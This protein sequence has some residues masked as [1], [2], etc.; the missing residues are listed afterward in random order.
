MGGKI[1]A[2]SCVRDGGI[3][4]GKWIAHYGG[5]LGARNL[6][7]FLDGKDQPLPQAPGV[8]LTVLEHQK[9]DRVAG[10][11]AR[12]ARLSDKAAELFAAGYAM[13]IATD[14]D[15]YLVADPATGL[16]LA[17]YLLSLPARPSWSAL[18]LDV[19]QHLEHETAFDPARPF[20]DQ[21]RFAQVSARYTKASVTTRPL[22]WG[23][24]MHRVKGR[25]FRIAPDLFLIH[26]GMIDAGIAGVIGRDATRAEAGWG[27]HQ[28]RREALFETVRSS[29]P[30]MA[31][32]VFAKARRRMSLLRPVYAWNKPGRLPGDA[33]VVLPER[34][35]GLL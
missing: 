5:A 3:F 2:I 22:R 9:L 32:E 30:R 1:A 4:T 20:L 8:N 26:A 11:K 35:R 17:D 24:G 12:A 34:F 15:E 13:V 14:I 18:G 19:V 10:D 29:R 25:N 23:S 16:G 33:V 27:G 7:L 31:D 21:R 6:H 28:A